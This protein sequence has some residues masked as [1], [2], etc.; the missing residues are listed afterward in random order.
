[1]TKRHNRVALPERVPEPEPMEPPPDAA[2]TI[3]FKVPDIPGGI[4]DSGSPEFCDALRVF[5]TLAGAYDIQFHA[6][7]VKE[8]K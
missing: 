8:A 3:E 2:I 4:T 5:L 1:M 6:E 7:P